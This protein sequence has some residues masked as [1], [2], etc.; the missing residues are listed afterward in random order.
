MEHRGKFTQKDRQSRSQLAK[1]AGSKRLLCGSLV[2][3]NEKNDQQPDRNGQS[4]IC[5][6]GRELRQGHSYT[7]RGRAA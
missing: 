4:I 3:I 2:T 1:L 7:F 5:G 6:I